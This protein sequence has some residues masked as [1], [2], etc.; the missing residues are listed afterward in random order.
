M[1]SI[2]KQ[3]LAATVCV[4][5]GFGV[6]ALVF[7]SPSA[8]PTPVPEAQILAR[9]G[10]EVITIDQFRV[11]MERRGGRLPGQ[12]HS[13][14]QKQELL[15][16]MVDYRRQLAAA[17]NAGYGEDPDVVR[18]IEKS[19]ISRFHEDR[20]DRELERQQVTDDHVRDW[21][22][23]NQDDYA[24]PARYRPALILLPAPTNGDAVAWQSLRERADLILDEAA[25]LAPELVHWGPLAREH[26][27]HR[28][29]RYNGGAVGWLTKHAGQRYAWETEVVDAVFALTEPGEI[30]PP[31]E[32]DSGI[33]LVRLMALERQQP[34]PL[35]AVADGIRYHLTRERRRAAKEKML[36]DLTRGA[37]VEIFADRLQNVQPINPEQA[38]ELSPPS[39]PKS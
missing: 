21:Y 23:K 10:D 8:A 18:V 14:E 19:V 24:V 16:A 5:A 22:E 33:F 27:A 36:T 39:L 32:T 31:I 17:Q 6:G 28:S 34:R 35:E 4:A 29:S 7:R 13:V 9:F 38:E 37:K 25:N 20:L 2:A 11:E 1:N 15:E 12:F 30:A 26:S 3:A